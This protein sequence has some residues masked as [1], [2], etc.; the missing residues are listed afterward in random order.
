MDQ[1]PLRVGSL[2]PWAHGNTRL[3][4]DGLQHLTL[5]GLR[6]ER[7]LLAQSLVAVPHTDVWHVGAPD[8]IALRTLLGV[9][10]AQPVA[11]YLQEVLGVGR[12]WSQDQTAHQTNSWVPPLPAPHNVEAM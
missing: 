1:A 2:R 12:G 4:R 8:V 10:G 9:V 7:Q 6:D 11:L 5:D 3:L